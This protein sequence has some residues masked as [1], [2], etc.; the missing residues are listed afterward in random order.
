ME[1]QISLPGRKTIHACDAQ[2]ARAVV[3]EVYT[4]DTYEL[5]RLTHRT[6]TFVDI[7]AN[8]GAFSICAR[9]VA[10]FARIIAFEPHPGLF[11]CLKKN[12]EGFN[13]ETHNI[14][15]GDGT[16]VSCT[17]DQQG[18]G[19]TQFGNDEKGIVQS[20]GLSQIFKEF[21][22]KLPDVFL[23]IDCEGGERVLLD[24]P[25]ALEI[26]NSVNIMALELHLPP[27]PSF[28]HL[29]SRERWQHFYSL[30][31]HK[32]KYWRDCKLRNNA[33]IKVEEVRGI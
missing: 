13:I 22:V 20:M 1:C 2:S 33:M 16:P 3:G 31:R 7:G 29:P 18:T 11:D 24:N 25:A 10:P 14:A 4:G 5:R 32:N 30:C 17:M 26:V 15:L 9:K 28:K 12:T 21:D 8:I 19:C 27:W 6:A 23:K